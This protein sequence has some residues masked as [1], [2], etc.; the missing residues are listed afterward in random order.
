MTNPYDM[1]TTEELNVLRRITDAWNAFRAL[2]CVHPDETEEFRMALQRLNH[3]IF[4]RPFR[5]AAARA[6]Q[7]WA[8][9]EECLDRDVRDIPPLDSPWS[10]IE[11]DGID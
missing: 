1:L 8:P 9:W 5:L 3:L 2:P 7:G 6:V 11:E 10:G 4:A